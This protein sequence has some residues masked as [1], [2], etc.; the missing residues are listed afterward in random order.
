MRP[1]TSWNHVAQH[2]TQMLDYGFQAVAA[3]RD[4]P[5]LGMARPGGS[6]A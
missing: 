5:F 6:G 2:D 1:G 3:S 4:K